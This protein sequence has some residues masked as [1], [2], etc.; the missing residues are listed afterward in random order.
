MTV[1]LVA[2]GSAGDVYPLVALGLALRARGHRVALLSNGHFE[3]LSRRVSLEFHE[4]APATDYHSIV[5]KPHL[6]EPISGFR[7]V[8]EWLVL[9]PMR[10]TFAVISERIVPHETVVVAPVSAFGARIA[11][12]RLKIPLVTVCVQPSILRSLTQPPVLKPLPLSPRMPRL[13][14]QCW[15]WL[16]DR[17]AVDPLVRA[18]TDAFRAELNLP[19]VRRD[20]ATWSMS[21]LRVLG[22]F[23]EWYA[24]PQ[25]DWPPQVRLTGFPLF[26]EGE[27]TPLP[28]EATEFLDAGGPPIVFTPG[29]AMRRGR[30]FFEAAVEAAHQLE[31]RAVLVTQYQDQI[32][33]GLPESIR[34]FASL[35][36][37]RLFPRASLVVHHGGIGTASQALSAG[38]PQVVIPMAFDQHDNASRLER[39]GVARSLSSRRV[40]GRAM[41]RAIAELLDSRE[42]A[43]CCRRSALRLREADIRAETCRLIEEAATGCAHRPCN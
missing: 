29:S 1:L 38:V 23:P 39:L 37:S 17:V 16:T 42:V 19:P 4:V 26:D 33:A 32:P 12:E 36:F 24:R 21:P 18:E 8:V 10:R 35:P 11:Q 20:F 5:E 25:A 22:L 14:N 13:W 27:I 9:R 6:W 2:L 43:D 3:L 7:L 34:S 40:T 15:L 30:A 41:A 31:T 28:A